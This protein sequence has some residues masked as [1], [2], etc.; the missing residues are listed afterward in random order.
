MCLANSVQT[1]KLG[2]GL[3]LGLG[4]VLIEVAVYDDPKIVNG[5]ASELKFAVPIRGKLNPLCRVN[6]KSLFE[7]CPCR[8][9]FRPS[10]SGQCMIRLS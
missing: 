3:G 10:P 7:K 8:C 6:R 5:D 4:V 2:L 1:K 9:T